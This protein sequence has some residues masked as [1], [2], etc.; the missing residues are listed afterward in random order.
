MKKRVLSILLSLVLVLGLVPVSTFADSAGSAHTHC[1][2]GKSDCGDESH[3]EEITWIGISSLSEIETIGG[4][5]HYYLKQSVTINERW[6]LYDNNITLCLNG[7][8][9]RCRNSVQGDT[10]YTTILNHGILTITDCGTTGTIEYY[11]PRHP[12]VTVHNRAGIFNL[13]NGTISGNDSDAGLFNGEICNMYGGRI[14]NNTTSDTYSSGGVINGGTFNMYGGEITDNTATGKG[15][16]GGVFNRGSNTFNMYGGTIT[17]NKGV[18]AGGMYN[19]GTVNFSGTPNISGNTVDGVENNVYLRNDGKTV[20]VA[21]GGM[22]SGASVGITGTIGETVIT[23]TTSSAGFF[24]DNTNYDFASDGNGGLKLSVHDGHRI[25]GDSGCTDDKHGNTLTF[26]GINDLSEIN[27]DGNYYLKKD[28][29]LDDDM[30]VCLYNV[31]L[32]LNGKSIIGGTYK[33]TIGVNYN[34]SLTITDCQET[35]GKITHKEGKS[36]SGIETYAGSTLNLW[37]GEVSGNTDGSGVYNKE[38]TFNMYGGSISNNITGADGGGVLNTEGGTFNLYGGSISNNSA[39]NNDGGG[40]KNTSGRFNM[41]GGSIS[42]NTAYRF[43]GGVYNGSIFNM[44]GGTISGNTAQSRGGGVNNGGTFTMYGGTISGNTATSKGGGVNNDSTFTMSDGTISEN[45]VTNTSSCGAGVNNESTFTMTGGSIT[46]NTTDIA[47][48]YGA[49]VNN[50]FNATFNMNGGSITGNKN[51]S[52]AGGIYNSNILNITGGIISGNSSRYGGGVYNWKSL[53]MTGGSITG[54]I[55][56]GSLDA[57]GGGI[58][59]NRNSTLSMSS[60]PT[61]TGNNKGGSMAADGTI[62]GGKTENV[63][64]MGTKT[65]NVTGD[66]TD[67]A[68]VGISGT[69]GNTVV[70][71]TSDTKGFFSDET[72]YFLKDDGNGGLMLVRDAKV[73]G[74][75][76]VK[77]GG[78]EL[79]DGAKTY[80]ANAVVFADPTVQISGDAVENATYKYVWQKKGEDGTYAT[81]TD[82][83]DSTGPADAGDYTVTVTATKNN[84]ELASATWNFTIKKAMLRVNFDVKDKTYNGDTDATVIIDSV[85]GM[86]GDVDYTLIPKNAKFADANVGTDI[87]VTADLI[88]E[89]EA[90]KNYTV[91]ERLQGAANITPKYLNVEVS[92]QD[93]TYDG[94]TDAALNARIDM[95]GV[96]GND[97]VILVTDGVT[98]SFDTKNVGTGKTVTLF[99]QYTLSGAAARNYTVVQPDTL[100]ANITKKELTVENLT[101]ANKFYDGLSTAAIIG[102]PTLG[103]LVENDDV[104]LVNGTPDFTSVA[105]GENIPVSFTEF[106]LSGADIDNYTLIQPDG[107]TANI[108]PYISDKS[109]YTVNSNDWLNSDFVVTAQN[110]WLLSYTNTAEGEW[111]DTLTVSQENSN[112]TLNYYVKNKQSGIIS[113]MIAESYKIDK[114]MPT[115]IIRIDT[116]NWWKEFLNAIT[117]NLFYKDDQSVAIE[118]SDTDSGID[119]IEYLLTAEDLTVE[120]LADKTFT[121]YESS[122]LIKPDAE[123]IVYAKITDV[124]GNAAYLRSDGI[125][126]DATAPVINGAD[127]GKTYCGAVTLTVTEDHLDRVTLNDDV[128]T[129][130]DGKLTVEPK[131]GEQTVVATDMAGNSTTVTITVNDGHTWSGWTSN[132]DNTHSRTCEV[133][134]THTETKDCHGGTATCQVKAVCD[135]CHR[136]YGDYGP[137]DWDLTAWGYKDENGHAHTCKTDGCTNHSTL[138]LHIKSRDEATEEDPVICTECGYQIADALGHICANHLTPV[139][140]KDA[141]CTENGNKAYY[142]CT[143]GK[144][145]EDA[146]ASIEITDRDS[147]IKNALGHDWAPATCTEPKTCKRDGCGATDG[148]PLGHN[149]SNE[150]SSD[151]TGHWHDCQNQGCTEKEGFAQHTPGAAATETEAQ[152][153]TECGYVI[154]DALGHLCINHLTPVA[155]KDATCTENGNTAY[156]E[157]TC[158]KFYEDATASIE[159]TDRDSVIKNAL[160]HDWAP[161]TCTEPKTCKRD[162]C[163]AT[164]GDP[165]GHNYSNEW[166]SDA[167]GHWHDC[168]NQGCTEKEGFAQHT[169]GAAAT[170]TEAQTCTEC[171]YVIAPSLGH[172]CANHLTPVEAKDATCTEDGNK[173]YYECTC[174]K[175]YEDATASIEITDHDSVIK[176]ALGHDWAPATCTKPKTCKRDGCG[177][178]DGDPLG[179]NYAALWSKDATGHWHDCQNEGCTEKG[180]FAPHTP[181]TA[182]TETEA[183]TCTECGYVIAPSLGHI[184]ANHLT[185][186]EAKDATC[187]EDGNKAYYECSC[188]KL[189]EDATAG[190]EITKEQTVIPSFDREHEYEW[191]IDK[192]ATATENGVKHEECK[193]C[194]DKKA[195]VEIPATDKTDETGSKTNGTDS[196]TNSAVPK[197]GDN[198]MLGLWIA[199]L[200]I[201]IAGA[202]VY[203]KKKRNVK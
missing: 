200:F 99:G 69:L 98:A 51:N 1:V 203:S 27:K 38:S 143:C 122:F 55:A 91:P 21:E 160:G 181:G 75:L 171:G 113:E 144:F 94:N 92:A 62:T 201:S 24:C 116:N 135:D 193:I 84:E 25:C 133:D 169:P 168:Q 132:G 120:Q 114:T 47:P 86:I 112:G 184:C 163:G 188:G 19:L 11:N 108:N 12:G 196:K 121:E 151:A 198:Y 68:S 173:A 155:A 13:W 43:G 159:I 109:E 31:N 128:V 30:W 202:T 89:G 118:A 178:T 90:A 101:V 71:G 115:G 26:K 58:Y 141:T 137:H 5:G 67:G 85:V 189:Y 136:S 170:E 88:L 80:D 177:A 152:T 60:A 149:Y 9:I 61:V 28:V 2:C 49:G 192:E 186:V 195:S 176:N 33:S 65:V 22:S 145:Y 134:A 187:T 191:K 174:G 4:K 37:N 87:T 146:T 100:T 126:L 35:V 73:S 119:T 124:A 129:L 46:G 102:T 104:A 127:N 117:F 180:D 156:Y 72:S 44:S 8:S 183:Q 63:Y 123:L 103:G 54:N 138:V 157:C 172:I 154:A 77:E 3:G 82:L 78:E 175:F 66:I 182:P 147:V 96:I 10:M 150:W 23:G 199:L 165:L 167:T 59:N 64:L 40:V 93:K 6:L 50:H 139:E 161:A 45:T 179:H 110:G 142:E 52:F 83:T 158:G 95:S 111:V 76:L 18:I 153:C 32:C 57:C 107:I 106:S 42:G 185:P 53:A 131:A 105:A 166:S 140:A 48:S 194:H 97:E 70:S 81:L 14:R 74:K 164:D 15:S 16:A 197:T 130:T 17:D 7:Y 148:D 125:V 20:A 79:T 34:K 190:V 29:S 36:G 162:G 56:T 41:Y 39:S